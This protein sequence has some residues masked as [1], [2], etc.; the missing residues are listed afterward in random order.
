MPAAGGS[1]GTRGYGVALAVLGY[2]GSECELGAK[3]G[4]GASWEMSS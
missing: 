2:I 4:G 3:E 1:F